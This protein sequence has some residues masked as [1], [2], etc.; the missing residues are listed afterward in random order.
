MVSWNNFWPGRPVESGELSTLQDRP[1]PFPNSQLTCCSPECSVSESKYKLRINAGDVSVKL[2][3][4]FDHGGKGVSAQDVR[5]FR[6]FRPKKLL[7]VVAGRLNLADIS[8]IAVTPVEAGFSKHT[9]KLQAARSDKWLKMFDFVLPRGLADDHNLGGAGAL[10]RDSREGGHLVVLAEVSMIKTP[11]E[12]DLGRGS[13][14]RLSFG[15]AR[16]I[17]NQQFPFAAV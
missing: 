13:G 14:S 6:S 1:T 2:S 3:K 11:E 12:V 15:C 16:Q 4:P 7:D 5:I 17:H 9:C 10:R 8:D